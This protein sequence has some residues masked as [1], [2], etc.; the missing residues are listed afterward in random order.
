MAMQ[1]HK[2]VGVFNQETGTKY[3]PDDDEH[4][5]IMSTIASKVTG[6]NMP[7]SLVSKL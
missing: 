4:N 7:P 1:L 5:N 2:L 3:N 6:T